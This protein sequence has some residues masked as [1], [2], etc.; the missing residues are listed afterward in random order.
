MTLVLSDWNL[1]TFWV[2][3]YHLKNIFFCKIVEKQEYD[4]INGV[5]WTSV[6]N[7]YV[8]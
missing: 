2:L 6:E 3:I 7:K 4:G 8:F 1:I 5:K